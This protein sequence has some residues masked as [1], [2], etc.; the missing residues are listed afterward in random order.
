MNPVCV[1]S[2]YLS[3]DI[4]RRIM[5]DYFG[6]DVVLVMNI[7]DIDDKII[8]RA[9]ERNISFNDLARKYEKEYMDDMAR[10]GIKAPDCMTRVSEV[11]SHCPSAGVERSA[12][13]RM[14]G[15]P[16]LACCST[17]LR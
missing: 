13:P 10:L 7:T 17:S 12:H 8:D 4:L 16:L 15:L 3:F 11:G 9:T 6:Y 14:R 5:E 1:P 2:T